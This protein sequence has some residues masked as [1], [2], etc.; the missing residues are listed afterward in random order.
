MEDFYITLNNCKRRVR[1]WYNGR[2]IDRNEYLEDFPQ[3]PLNLH[4]DPDKLSQPMKKLFDDKCDKCRNHSMCK[5]NSK[6]CWENLFNPIP[7]GIMAYI[8]ATRHKSDIVRNKI[9]EEDLARLVE[10][11]KAK[12]ALANNGKKPNNQTNIN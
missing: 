5:Y 7:N 8:L 10:E 6:D 12:A 4:V 11:Y 1:K 9:S 3:D 2:Y